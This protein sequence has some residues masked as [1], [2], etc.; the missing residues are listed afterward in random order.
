VENGVKGIKLQGKPFEDWVQTQLPEGTLQTPW[1]YKIIDRF[2]P[3]TRI[4]TSTKTLNTPG[5]SYQGSTAVYNTL[6]GYVD[7]LNGFKDGPEYGAVASRR[8]RRARSR[9]SSYNWECR[10]RRTPSSGPRSTRPSSTRRAW[11]SI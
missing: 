5:P 10:T 4:A 3:N 8:S 2:N 11:E 6:K 7:A 1:S 9:A